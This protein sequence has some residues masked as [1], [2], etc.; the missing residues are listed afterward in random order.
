MEG[1]S[2]QYILDT[3]QS[4]YNEVKLSLTKEHEGKGRREAAVYIRHGASAI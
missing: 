2:Q 3:K 4:T 1:V